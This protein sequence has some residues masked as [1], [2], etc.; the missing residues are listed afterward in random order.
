MLKNLLDWLSRPLAPNDWE[1]GSAA[2]GKVVTISS[3][4]GKSAGAGV[5]KNLS[6][7]LTVMK[8]NLVGGMGTGISADADTFATDRLNLSEEN[9]EALRAQAER[10]L[11]QI[12]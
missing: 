11:S 3:V 6:G 10:F 7:L 9:R 2:K 1:R 4:A 8:M 12:L 5:R